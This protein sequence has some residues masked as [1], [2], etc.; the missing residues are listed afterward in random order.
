MLQFTFRNGIANCGSQA[1][2]SLPPVFYKGFNWNRFTSFVH[3][4][5]V[6]GSEPQPEFSGHTRD[7]VATKLKSMYFRPIRE[8]VCGVLF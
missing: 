5:S 6:A 3:V 1:G 8:K 2:S 7:H 4:V